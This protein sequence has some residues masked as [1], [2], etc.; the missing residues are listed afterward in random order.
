MCFAAEKEGQ[1]DL[2]LPNVIVYYQASLL[3]HLMQ[4]WNTLNK[5]S[6]ELG[7]IKLIYATIRMGSDCKFSSSFAYY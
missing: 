3:E 4:Q 1:G 5:P 2:A 6:W 7:Q